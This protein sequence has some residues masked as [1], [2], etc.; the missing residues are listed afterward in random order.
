MFNCHF[1]NL[2][3]KNRFG[4]FKLLAILQDKVLCQVL[5]RH[6][7]NDAKHILSKQ[8]NRGTMSAIQTFLHQLFM[9]HNGETTNPN[10]DNNASLIMK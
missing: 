8:Q 5:Y 4:C 1:F 2:F 7:V 6:L 9:A 3:L 10:D